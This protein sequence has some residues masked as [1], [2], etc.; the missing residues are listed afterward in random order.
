MPIQIETVI[1]E[2]TPVQGDAGGQ[3][4]GDKRWQRQQ[5]IESNYDHAQAMKMR[6]NGEDFDD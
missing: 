3:G 1:N 6:I 4:E 5:E 2:I